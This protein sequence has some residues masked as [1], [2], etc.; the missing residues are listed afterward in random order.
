MSL[1]LKMLII[2]NMDLIT[3]NALDFGITLRIGHLEIY[4]IEIVEQ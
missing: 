2:A 3:E 1:F 4:V